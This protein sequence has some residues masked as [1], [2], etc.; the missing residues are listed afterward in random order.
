MLTVTAKNLE[1]RGIAN[2]AKKD[3]SVYYLVNVE[4]FEGTPYQFY[5]KDSSAFDDGL[6]RGSIVDV[7]FAYHKFGHNESLTVTHVSL[8]E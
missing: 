7:T 6:R 1:L 5:C 8:A 3:G 4:D 2:R